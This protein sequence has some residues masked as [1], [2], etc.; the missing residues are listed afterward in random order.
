MSSPKAAIAETKTANVPLGGFQFQAAQ[1]T[2]PAPAPAKS[3][4]PRKPPG[5]V[6]PKLIAKAREL[7]DRYLEHVNASLVLP[8]S[9][10]K[11]DVSRTPSAIEGSRQ[12]G[13]ASLTHG[14]IPLLKA[15]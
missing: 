14:P 5:K 6:D 7:R 8:A 1:P 11:Y 10:G 2:A 3:K 13:A 4:P 12:R 9:G 15:G